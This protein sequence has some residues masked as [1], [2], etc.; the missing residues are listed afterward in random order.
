[1]NK[2]TYDWLNKAVVLLGLIT[3]SIATRIPPQPRSQLETNDAVKNIV[4]NQ[5][6]K[7]DAVALNYEL[8][9]STRPS[10]YKITLKPYL[11]PDKSK[12]EA[13]KF[14]S[15]D[16]TVVIT[17]VAQYETDT[18]ELNAKNLTINSVKIEDK[19]SKDAKEIEVKYN[20]DEEVE[21]LSII[22]SKTKL[23][24]GSEY[25]L[26]I[27]YNGT[28]DHPDLKGFYKSTYKNEKGE[29]M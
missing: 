10:N 15:F 21:K 24:K 19:P 20:L 13:G 22:L 17:L 1:M 4:T 18:I 3:I 6:T 26:T 7:D 23:Q 29:E 11:V 16:G 14:L 8:S 28:L 9:K 2:N 12:A 5:L 25:L 27:T